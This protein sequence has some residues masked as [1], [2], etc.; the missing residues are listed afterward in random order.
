MHNEPREKLCE[1]IVEYGRSLCADPRRCEALLKDYCGQYKREIFVL[2]SALKN[3][4]AEDLLKTSAG[5]PQ[6]LLLARLIKRLEDELGLAE[7]AAKW[8]VETWALALGVVQQPL[9]V[10]KPTPA[11]P[12]PPV[13][14]SPPPLQKG[15]EREFLASLTPPVLTPLS[16]FRDRLRDGSAGPAMIAIPAGGFWM[17]SPASEAERRNNEGR[18]RVL[19]ARPFAIGQYA[20]TFDEYDRYCDEQRKTKPKDESW[21]RGKRPVIN[22]SWLDA[23]SY[24]E[25][26]SA[27]TGQ[28]YRLPTEAEWEYA[29]RAGT[30]TAFWWG[31]DISPDQANYNG[32]YAYRRY[33]L[34]GTYREKIVPVDQFQSNPWE[35]Y[36]VHGNIWEWTGSQYNETYGGAEMQCVNKNIDNPLAVRGGSWFIQPAW[37]RSA[38]RDGFDPAYRLNDLGFRLSR[39]L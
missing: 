22:V 15:S 13:V 23:L 1:L 20:V 3:R 29:A 18:H 12:L 5:V 21:G 2:I 7:T 24:T 28:N 19:I 9:P 30:E 25:W 36:Q 39:S 33:G 10:I 31:D 34:K 37:V 6:T 17:G 26:L 8:A 35:L 27:Q 14:I 38:S 32:N 4:V 16:V 11:P